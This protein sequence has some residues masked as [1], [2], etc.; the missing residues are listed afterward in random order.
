MIRRDVTFVFLLLICWLPPVQAESEALW[1]AYYQQAKEVQQRDQQ[2]LNAELKTLGLTEFTLPTATQRFGFDI[3]A[4]ASWYQTA[5]G[6]QVANA[7]LSLQTP[8]GGWSKRTDMTVP[9]EAGQHWGVEPKYVPTFDNG[10]TTTQ[11]KVLA[12]AYSATADQRYKAAFEHGVALLLLAQYP[13]GGWPQNY[14]LTGG[15]HD[16]VTL[17]DEA[18]ENILSLLLAVTEGKQEFSFVDSH[19]QQ[20]AQQAIT[21]GVAL[22]LQIQQ[23]DEAGLTLWAAQ[24]QHRELT[25]AW[26]RAY[27]MPALAVMESATLLDLLM[28]LPEP[29]AAL[30]QAIHGAMAWLQRHA[31]YDKHWHRTERVLQDKPGAGPLW[32]RFAEL[33]SNRAIFGD[34][35]NALYYDVH[36]VSLERRQGYAWYTDRPAR[37]L[38]QYQRWQQQFP[39]AVTPK[40]E[41]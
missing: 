25:P 41:R 8:S 30:Q 34:R 37:T 17:N 38:E 11:L 28:Q 7:I 24:Y 18:T 32:P 19:L 3:H 2:V 14:P 31:I 4:P 10:A 21:K 26:A 22:L 5:A 9:R 36:Q 40:P 39:A 13:N 12:K 23:R 20:Q 15:Y 1:Q 35:D 16:H 27:E 33:G 6:K 29:S